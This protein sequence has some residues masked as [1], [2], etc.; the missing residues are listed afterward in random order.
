MRSFF[1]VVL[2]IF[3][4]LAAA[5]DVDKT[6]LM[7][8]WLQGKGNGG[9]GG[10]KMSAALRALLIARRDKEYGTSTPVSSASS[11]THNIND[12]QVAMA[13]ALD[14][15]V[16]DA[17]KEQQQLQKDAIAQQMAI[18]QSVE[19]QNTQYVQNS[20]AFVG[21]L[22]SVDT[23]TK[24]RAAHAIK[25]KNRGG[26][27]QQRDLSDAQLTR[28]FGKSGGKKRGK[29]RGKKTGRKPNHNE[30]DEEE[31]VDE[32]D[33]S[34]VEEVHEDADQKEEEKPEAKPEGPA[35]AWPDW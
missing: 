20:A 17:Y 7:K 27:K 10:G 22:V 8:A 15:K 25:A 14:A 35:E 26:L 28:M 9:K 32:E 12:V 23:K 34:D 1:L 21:G 29:K 2:A 11:N 5:E 33:N 31:A 13:Q 18:I 19:E 6:D 30:V 4:A 16:K 24:N 3:V